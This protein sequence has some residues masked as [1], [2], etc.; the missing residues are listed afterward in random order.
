MI[1]D[2]GVECLADLAGPDD[3][4]LAPVPAVAP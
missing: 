3:D 4:G 1:K 2:A